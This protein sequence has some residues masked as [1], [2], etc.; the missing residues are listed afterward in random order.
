M[1]TIPELFDLSRPFVAHA[2]QT[3]ELLLGL[4]ILAPTVVLLMPAVPGGLA[5]NGAS[6]CGAGCSACPPGFPRSSLLSRL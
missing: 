5:G 1:H 6:P 3:A 4:S 2:P